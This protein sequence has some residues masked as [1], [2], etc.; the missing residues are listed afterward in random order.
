MFDIGNVLVWPHHGPVRVAAHSSRKV[1]GETLD[2]LMLEPVTDGASLSLMVP[3]NRMDTAGWRPLATVDEVETLLAGM[4]EGLSGRINPTASWG[5]KFKTLTAM[6]ATGELAAHSY[7]LRDL[8]PKSEAGSLSPA[9]RRMFQNVTD[10]FVAEV[11]IACDVAVDV[12][13]KRMSDALAAGYNDAMA[14][15]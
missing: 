12:A 13:D 2:Y 6:F 14:T 7:V 4:A 10:R 5:E 8:Y 3:V 1:E 9:E 11:A 15:A